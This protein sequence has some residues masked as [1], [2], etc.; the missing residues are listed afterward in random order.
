MPHL[1]SLPPM[2]LNRTKKID[3]SFLKNLIQSQNKRSS[4][5]PE[6]IS[7]RLKFPPG[8]NQAFTA[9]YILNGSQYYP[10]WAYT[11]EG[12]LAFD[13]TKSGFA[14]SIEK[15]TGSI[16]FDLQTEFRV[17]PNL[18]GFDM[19]QVGGDGKCY[20]YLFFQWIISILAPR[21]VINA[22]A[23]QSPNQKVNGDD[24]TVW[25]LNQ[26]IF[27]VRVSDNTLVQVSGD[28]GYYGGFATMTLSNVKSGVDPSL[29]SRPST[30]VELLEWSQDWASHL[31][32]FIWW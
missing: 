3:P 1:V 14:F 15:T 13:F 16:P 2:V 7:P 22:E 8:L 25:A 5:K 31:P 28:I 9:S 20:V 10:A 32:R 24:C 4:K 26:N 30:C 29:Y 18:N 23:V 21:F 11:F 17:S 27:W 6:E 19:I 12:K